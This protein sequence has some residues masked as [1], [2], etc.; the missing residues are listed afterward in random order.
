[1][2]IAWRQ[3]GNR[4]PRPTGPQPWDPAGQHRPARFRELF[5]VFQ[6]S[7]NEG[8]LRQWTI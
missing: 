8:H 5:S 3:A 2:K 7:S 1:M 6:R 4:V